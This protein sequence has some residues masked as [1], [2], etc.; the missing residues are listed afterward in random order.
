MTDE[1]S[2]M[3]A[4]DVKAHIA[5]IS[6]QITVTIDTTTELGVLDE[7][8]F[9]AIGETGFV[10]AHL[11]VGL[12][13]RLDETIGD[14]IVDAVATDVDAERSITAPTFGNLAATWTKRL[15]P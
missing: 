5:G 12:V 4:S 13:A 3:V 10:D 7:C 14:A 15:P 1:R 2:S 6:L 11:S 9:L 8:S